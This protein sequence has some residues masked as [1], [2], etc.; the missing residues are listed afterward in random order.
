MTTTRAREAPAT[1]EH[2]REAPVR[3]GF[4]LDAATRGA[5]EA[6]LGHDFSAVRVHADDRAAATARE[7]HARAFTVGT[8]VGFAAGAYRP[9]TPQG[10]RLIAHELAHVVQQSGAP[11]L[12]RAPVHPAPDRAAPEREASDAARTV[13]AGGRAVVRERPGPGALLEDEKEPPGAGAEI[14]KGL[15]TFVDKAKDDPKIKKEIIEP[16]TDAAKSRWDALSGGEKGAVVGFGAAT[17]G[18]GVGA[19]LSDPTG[20]RT[21]QGFNLAAPLGLVPYA[22]LTSF[23]YQLPD[24]KD[25]TY[26]FRTSV[27]LG[28]LIKAAH[29]W[30]GLSL[31]ADL[32]WSWDPATESLSLAGGTARLGLLP[33]VSVSGG[34]YP[35]LLGFTPAFA[36]PD[37]PGGPRQAFDQP[38][39]PNLPD[40]RVVLSIDLLKLPTVGP[41][42]RGV[43]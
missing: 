38:K 7:L 21:L 43:F 28:D 20:R 42:L 33:G 32:S 31:S 24:A 15:S 10:R 12:A 34:T 39:A 2:P 1:R 17:Y 25:P 23:S 35:S 13:L 30:K 5:M 41:A 3:G 4:P 26:R 40:T 6:G 14:V 9:S 22:T 18:L 19:M 27:D 36:P 29:G 11:G 16:V 8:D 37:L